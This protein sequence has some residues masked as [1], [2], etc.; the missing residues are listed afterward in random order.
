MRLNRLPDL[1]VNERN[2]SP[3]VTHVQ[4]WQILHTLL[5]NPKRQCLCVL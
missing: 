3:A 2:T 1:I 5:F 4:V